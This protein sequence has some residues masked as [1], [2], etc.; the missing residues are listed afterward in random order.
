MHSILITGGGGYLGRN[1]TRR[2][3]TVEKP[4]RIVILSRGEYAQAQMAQ[5]FASLDPDQRLRFFIGDVRERD[6]LRRAFDGVDTVVHAAALKRIE[7][8]A[9]NPVEMVRTNI[10]GTINVIE[11]AMDAHVQK[12]VGISSDK[13]YQPVSPYGQS[14]ALGESLLLNANNMRGAHGPIF[15]ICRYG[16]VLC[17]TGSVVPRWRA[18]LA[19]GITKVPVTSPAVTRYMMTVEQAVDL[20]L[21]T[22]ETM[23]GGELAIPDLPAYRLG[24]L[25]EAMGAEMEVIG[26]PEW[27]KLHENLS[28]SQCSKDARRLSVEELRSILAETPETQP[29]RL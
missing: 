11:A 27:E 20:V 18:L 28:A 5:E 3:L 29:A 15:S 25:A 13:A 7:V 12:V 16:N 22:A 26:L 4:E 2:L 8:G 17:S 10:L 21:S 14:K 6:R 1:L 23:Q 9:M 19:K 24:D